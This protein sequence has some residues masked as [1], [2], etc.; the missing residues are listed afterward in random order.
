[1]RVPIL[2]AAVL[3]VPLLTPGPPVAAAEVWRSQ[4]NEAVRGDVAIIGNSVLTCPT[5][6][7]AG[8]SPKYPPQSCV[9]AQNRKGHGP[10]AQ[11]N[12]HRMSWTDV[13]DDPRTFNSSTAT[14]AVP[15]AAT[16]AY[17]KLGWAGSATCHDA[18]QP[19]GR[20]EDPVMLNGTSVSPDRFAT[21][22]PNT[23]SPTDNTFY[24]AEADVTRR[25]TGRDIT[26]G[27]IWAPQ[28]FD[29]FG[30]WS[31]TVVWKVPDAP[32]RHVSVHGGHVRLPTKLPTVRTPI[33]PT[34]AAGGITK[35]SVTAYEGDWASDG[36][37]MLVNDTSIAGRNAFTSSAQGA[38]HPNNMSVDARTVTV[39]EDVLRPGARSAELTF[40]RDDDA[41]LVQNVAWSF[42]LPELSLSVAPEHPAAHPKD[43]VAQTAT[44]TNIGDAP[45]ADVSVCGQKIGTIAPHAKAARTCTSQAADDDYQ[46][47]VTANGISRA[48][49]PLTAQ[50][51]AKV[52][53]LH[54]ALRATTT[55]EP[56]TALPGQEVKFSTTVTNIGDTALFDL[57]ARTSTNGC[58]P[59]Q[60]QLDPGATATVVCAAP[61][62]D[63]SGTLTAA[64]TAIDKIG[65]KV[66]ASA[67]VQVRVIHPRLTITA[68][69]SKDRAADGEPVTVT[70]TIG[71]PSD[72][73]INDVE[74]AGEPA[75]CRRTFPVLRPGERVTYTCQAIA[76]VNSRLTVSGAGASHV[77]SESAVVR[78]ESITTPLPP[79]PST[80]RPLRDEP[81]SPRPVAHV[82]QVSKPAVGGIAAV[83]GVIGMVIVAS[84]F[85]GLGKR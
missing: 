2:I 82:Q 26:V 66:E 78:I 14:L 37:Q 16:I 63:E 64:V 53:V 60:R 83:I 62:G 34:H 44:V 6:E 4:F 5:P 36:D 23:L 17:A 49:D 40:R 72:L 9:D 81:A 74:V 20:P 58:D 48:G 21:D 39:P 65:K 76:P 29:C 54:P 31:L 84:A 55:T 35:V 85:S 38:T 77:I 32:M 56:L 45:A 71:N 73:P 41:Y 43:N 3:L 13:D 1:M 22:E 68:L 24:S 79:E 18:R 28:G 19:P 15:P 42:P 59:V 46:T 7:Q 50:K 33:A 80:T 75:A 11:N 67:S 25:L 47:T 57:N 10:A 8:P 61:A 70:V 27:N 12:G 51:T 69:W 30:G 52:D